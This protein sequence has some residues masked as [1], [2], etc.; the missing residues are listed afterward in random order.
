MR[1][2]RVQILNPHQSRSFANLKV[3]KVVA[4]GYDLNEA[5]KLV[6]SLATKKFDESVTIAVNLG[7]D[8]RKPAEMV[9]GNAELPAGSGKK[10]TV[11]VFAQGKKAEEA[12]EAGAD[13]IGQQD[14]ADQ[15]AAGKIEFTRCIA[16][17]DMMGVVSKVARYLGPKGL[18]PNAKLGTVTANVGDAV[19]ASKK[20]QVSYKTEKEGIV[21]ALVGKSS[22]SQESL[23]QNLEA[24]I[25]SLQAQ[26]PAA[27]KGIY[28]RGAVL[29]SSMGPSV[30]LNLRQYPFTRKTAREAAATAAQ[31]SAAQ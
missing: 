6:K 19:L 5:V 22:F 24:F 31:P 7:V 4:G 25:L 11:A 30:R 9:R 26:K 17:P 3:R 2:A 23:A 1:L 29:S 13:I 14:L 20:G 12:R 15:I 27:S 10:V 21:H 8:P 28:F 18:M 16:T